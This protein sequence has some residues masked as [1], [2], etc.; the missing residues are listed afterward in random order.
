MLMMFLAFNAGAITSM[1]PGNFLMDQADP[2]QPAADLDGN[3]RLV[4]GSVE[5]DVSEPNP[6]D[7]L[8]LSS[9]DYF[10]VQEGNHFQGLV[11]YT[12]GG[13]DAATDEITLDTQSSYLLDT[14]IL[15]SKQF[16]SW[17]QATPDSVLMGKQQES[18][19]TAT[20]TPALA[21]F[22][23]LLSAKT[24]WTSKCT[25]VVNGIS[26]KAT[27][28]AK[29]SPQELVSVPAGHFLTWPIAYTLKA[30]KNGRT[31]SQKW[32]AWFAP[33][34]GAIKE[35]NSDYTITVTA[36]A[37]GA[38]AISIPPPVV[39]GVSLEQSTTESTATINGFQFG[40]AQ[41]SSVVRIGSI[42]CDDIVSWSDTQIQ[43]Y[44][45]DSASTGVVTV[46]TDTW[47][48]NDTVVLKIPPR[49]TQVAPTSG[50]RKSTVQ[51][52]GTHFGTGVGKVKFGS[53]SAKITQWGNESISCV[54]PAKLSYRAYPI[55]VSN[56]QGQSVL[57]GAFT[58]VK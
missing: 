49:I 12:N 6:E 17:L 25:A 44:I 27:L 37:V 1:V 40:A 55:S 50:Q 10:G 15:G 45:P 52:S 9:L 20:Y 39:T 54:V 24:R 34:I 14:E 33:Y 43:F 47:N 36:F 23:G 16:Q 13:T 53:T 46:A 22:K 21:I 31:A 7:P 41:G 38:G 3:R 8:S 58:V 28:S 29:V 30:S 56:K 18:G 48:S 19:N 42:E 4:G 2:D 32:I 35:T 51:I 11:S 26:M 5:I 57:Q